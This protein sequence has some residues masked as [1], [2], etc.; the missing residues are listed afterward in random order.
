MNELSPNPTGGAP[1]RGVAFSTE[2]PPRL[3]PA[4]RFDARDL[5]T[6]LFYHVR[7]LRICLLLGLLLGL[8]G[9][10]A[11][12]TSYTASSLLLVLIGP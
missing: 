1:H 2:A 3:P 10:L 9:V 11:A 8:A 6:Q 12:R 4:P 7:L 5:L